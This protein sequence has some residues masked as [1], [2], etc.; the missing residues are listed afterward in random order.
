MYEL[1]LELN[2]EVIVE[3]VAQGGYDPYADGWR[4]AFGYPV[5]TN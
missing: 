2:D 4:D 1:L 3:L 5:L